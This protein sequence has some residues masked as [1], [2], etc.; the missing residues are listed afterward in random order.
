MRFKSHAVMQGSPEFKL[1]V[2]S[3][4]FAFDVNAEGAVKLALG[5]ISARID[6]IPVTLTIPFLRRRGGAQ[7]IGAIGP[8]RVR[9]DALD[10]EV[11]PFGVRIGGLVGKDGMTCSLEGKIGCRT[12]FDVDGTIPGKVAKASVELVDERNA[13]G[14]AE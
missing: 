1:Q 3:S 7:T 2:T 13:E 11:R 6:E 9:L 5:P 14:A 8:F 4:P 12:E 10:L